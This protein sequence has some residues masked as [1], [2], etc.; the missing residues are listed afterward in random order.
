MNF[1]LSDEL[2]EFRD[3]LRKYF[4]EKVSSEVLRGALKNKLDDTK[5]VAWQ[6]M[7]NELVALGVTSA[8][9]SEKFDGLDFSTLA[10]E[11]IIEEQARALQPLPIFETIVLGVIPITV[12]GS[13]SAKK[14]ILPQIAKG[15]LKL[16]GGF[17]E[18]CSGEMPSFNNVTAKKSSGENY[19][20]SGHLEHVLSLD[21]VDKLLV[22]AR[23]EQTDQVNLFLV[24]LKVSQNEIAKNQLETF[25]LVRS[26]FNL[27]FK[28]AKAVLVGDEKITNDKWELVRSQV[29]ILASAELVGVATKVIEMCTDYVKT[30]NQFGKPIGGFQA[31]QHKLANML[32]DCE[33]AT[34]LARF[35]SWTVDSDPFQLKSAAYA[36]KAYASEVIPKIIEDAIQVHGGIG[37]TYEFDLHLYLR[38]ALTIAFTFGG[39]DKWQSSLGE[40]SLSS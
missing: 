35:A 20:L 4:T 6:A 21:K 16:S 33:Q 17:E 5:H 40:L 27:D 37:F 25:D 26:Y 12:L 31:I 38:R 3:V 7:W 15:E 30:R 18:V 19:L 1:L 23:I 32:L 10:W 28:N 36:L 8:G 34:S 29:L 9:I 11:V 24:D 2:I 22:P 14:S 39:K 13:A